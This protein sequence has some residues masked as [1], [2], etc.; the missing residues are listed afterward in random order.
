MA[1]LT[2]EGFEAKTL[3][4]IKAELE[5]GL[6]TEISDTLNVETDSPLGQLIGIF[7][8]KLREVWELAEE[9]YNSSYP[10][11]ASGFSLGALS[12][13][14]GTQRAPATRSRVLVNVDVDP[15]TY[16]AGTIVAHVE[17]DP[18]ARFV[19]AE[20]VVN[21]GPGA[22]TVQGVLF[23]AENTGPVRANSGTLTTIAE[24]LAGLNSITNPE[25]AELGAEVE[26]DTD[27][28]IRR[29]EELQAVGSTTAAAVRVDV[30][31]VEGV[32]SVTV[33]ENDTDETVDGIPPHALEAIVLGGESADI[34][35]AILAAKAGGIQAF[36]DTVVEVEDSQGV[37][38]QIGFTRPDELE[39]YLEIDLTA[40]DGE[41]GGSTEVQETLVDYGDANL[42]TK[43]GADV[44]LSKLSA[45]I[46]RNVTGILDVTEIRV[47]L[48]PSP[49]ST[50]NLAV[51][52]R[53]VADLDTSR[54]TVNVTL[55]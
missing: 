7:S 20:E 23:L 18:T 31:L 27:L 10:D 34:A 25:D 22:A 44:I 48:I 50:V 38:H 32:D 12:V 49:V 5:S 9:V 16:A 55:V 14:T 11:S 33:L 43:P 30:A 3:E 39:V 6:R 29:E 28:R 45:E 15:G 1:G 8:S 36:G 17:G 19:N 2:S 26:S 4:E 46:F 21:A 42:R 40:T 53:E 47:G 54:I 41:Y 24:P 52:S 37:L 13:L 35:E 51:G